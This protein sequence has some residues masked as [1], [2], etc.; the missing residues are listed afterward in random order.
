MIFRRL[1]SWFRRFL[2]EKE[3]PLVE[4]TPE[5]KQ[6]NTAGVR[7]KNPLNLKGGSKWIGRIGQDSR[8]HIIFKDEI[9]GTRAA[10]INLRS[11][12][13]KHRLRTVRQ[14]INRWAPPTDTIGSIPGNPKNNPSA[15][16]AFVSKKSGL[17]V[18]GEI[19]LFNNQG[20]VHDPDQLFRLID[21]MATYENGHKYRFDKRWFD[22]A[23]KLV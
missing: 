6:P 18:D 3:K 5:Y 20:G 1:R 19:A 8:G 4:A 13:V 15:Y 16:A 11:Y 10:I 17:P 9:Y 23:V 21:A 2:P 14:I 12:W 7:G 22:E